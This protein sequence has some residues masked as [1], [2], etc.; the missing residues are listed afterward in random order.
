MLSVIISFLTWLYLS[1]VRCVFRLL[2]L[3]AGPT[4]FLLPPIDDPALVQSACTLALWIRQRKRSAESIVE[5]F[6][7]RVE[8]V[9]PIINAVVDE[10]FEAALR[11]AREVDQRLD[12][13]TQEE[14]EETG[15][16]QPLLGVP[17]TAKENVLVKGLSCTHGLVLRRGMKAERDAEVV[18]RL[19]EAGAI[20]LAVTNVPE[21]GMWIESIN[22]LYGRTANPYDVSRTPGGSSGGEGALLASC[23]TPLSIGTDLIGSIRIPS[24]Y[25]GTFGHKPTSGWVS[26]DGCRCLPYKN[27]INRKIT[28]AGPMC[29][30][31]GDLVVFLE[32]MAPR[33]AG[34]AARVADTDIGALKIWWVD[35]LDSPWCRRTEKS[36]REAL[37][38]AHQHLQNS[39]GATTC[40]FQ[41]PM[42]MVHAVDIWLN[43]LAGENKDE[44]SLL[45]DMKNRKG[46]V[47]L[48]EEWLRWVCGRGRHSFTLLTVSTS[49]KYFYKK[50]LNPRFDWRNAQKKMLEI[51]GQNGVLLMPVMPE[52]APFHGE[53]QCFWKDMNFTAIASATEL[54]STSVPLGLSKEGLPLGLQIMTTPGNDHLSLAVAAALEDKFG[55]WISPSPITI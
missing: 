48:L 1:A 19:R 35:G 10:R 32:S 16:A 55:G 25:C 47:N 23:G 39:F 28:V 38:A 22:P 40:R 9:N 51:L 52:V 33:A 13:C 34:L 2:W 4:K 36:L 37:H 30:S 49:L 41:W 11:E 15:R 12:A 46:T 8:A 29:R 24:F 20:P 50:F 27:Y 31:V 45:T 26:L 17:F 7:R 44:P 54:P 43:K 21:L 14:R 53:P 6:R 42:D 5:A 18:C 3:P